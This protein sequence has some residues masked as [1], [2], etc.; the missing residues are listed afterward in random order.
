MQQWCPGVKSP[1]VKSPLWKQ[2]G[3]FISWTSVSLGQI[4]HT[5]LV[6]LYWALG[7]T[8]CK[9]LS[10]C[11][12]KMPSLTVQAHK[13]ML[14][15]KVCCYTQQLRFLGHA[16]LFKYIPCIHVKSQ[17]MWEQNKNNSKCGLFK[18]WCS[19]MLVNPSKVKEGE[20]ERKAMT[21]SN[22]NK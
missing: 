13:P 8:V 7:E 4:D 17:D 22:I 20:R 19:L 14:I 6:F 11:C 15:L 5:Q 12:P 18:H 9:G 10:G 2:Q 16:F 1:C 3:G 21:Y